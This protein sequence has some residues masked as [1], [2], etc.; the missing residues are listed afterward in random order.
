MNWKIICKLI[1]RSF[2][3]KKLKVMAY[4]DLTKGG[5]KK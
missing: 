1:R 2:R 5:L 3:S 4:I